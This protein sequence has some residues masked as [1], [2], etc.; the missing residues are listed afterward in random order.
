MMWACGF[1]AGFRG[2]FLVLG[3]E[4]WADCSLHLRF[5]SPL[6][7]WNRKTCPRKR[8]RSVGWKNSNVAIGTAGCLSCSPVTLSRIPEG[9]DVGGKRCA[10]VPDIGC[11]HGLRSG[12][13]PRPLRR[14]STSGFV[15]SKDRCSGP[16][17]LRN[18]FRVLR[19]RRKHNEIK[20]PY[21]A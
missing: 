20:L 15:R 12:G 9:A 14:R 1:A 19:N 2:R 6:S 4:A 13:F 8:G 17:D 21:G 5:R 10:V 16:G 3:G 7:P 18:V 11:R